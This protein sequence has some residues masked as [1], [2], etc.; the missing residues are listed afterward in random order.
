[1]EINEISCKSILS[2]SGIYSVDYSINP[3]VGCQHG[4]RYCYASFMRKYT[5]H[6]EPWGEFVDVKVNARNVLER[7]LTKADRGS[8]LLSSVTDPYQPAEREYGLT[9]GILERLASTKFQVSILTKSPLLLRDLDVLERF[10]SERISVGFT[11]NFLNDR[12]ESVWEPNSPGSEERIDAL[13]AISD[14]GISTYVHVGPY[15]EKITNLEDMLSRVEDYID[16]LQVENVNLRGRRAIIMDVI[17]QNYPDLVS[18]YE[19]IL[20]DDSRYRE[21]LVR[22]IRELRKRHEVPIQLFM[23]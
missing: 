17:R 21:D 1:M 6:D 5:D 23:D 15:L 9:R 16:E 19:R 3:Y 13:E 10:D 2:K 12:D 11:I 7:D 20:E 18:R 22:E 8:V 4:C 14:N